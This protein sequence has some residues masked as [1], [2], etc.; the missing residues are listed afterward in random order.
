MFTQ[1]CEP[2]AR[3]YV[4]ELEGASL[5]TCEY[6]EVV[7]RD[8][9]SGNGLRS[10]MTAIVVCMA[11]LYMEEGVDKVKRRGVGL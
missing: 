11:V 2:C 10:V 4:V 6:C 5:R 8:F 7:R 9:L 3:L 1:Q